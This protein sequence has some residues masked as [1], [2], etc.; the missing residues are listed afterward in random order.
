MRKTPFFLAAA[1]L[2][3][4]AVSA[5]A[6]G[7]GTS[8]TGS[9][10]INGNTGTNYFE[11]A[12]GYVPAGYGNDA[13]TTVTIGPGVEFGY[14][15]GANTDTADFTGTTLTFTDDSVSGSLPITYEFSDPA[16]TG[17][18]EISQTLGLGAS[19]SFSGDTLTISDAAID[20]GTYTLLIDYSSSS[21][22]SVTPE[23]SSL[24]LLGTGVLVCASVL[25]RRLF[26]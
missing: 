24:L 11:P 9:M 26:A 12:D 13:G 14:M 21:S 22:A 23:P 5:M 3:I 16:F 6:D 8:V 19:V 17:A 25:R 7:I 4:P 18:S 15:D 20:A 1:L 2:C 10:Y